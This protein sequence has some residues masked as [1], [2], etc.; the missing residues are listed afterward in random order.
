MSTGLLAL[1]M[2]KKMTELTPFFLQQQNDCTIYHLWL[3][4]NNIV[5]LYADY[6]GINNCA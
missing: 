5:Q 6:L 2:G 3:F 4:A 1:L